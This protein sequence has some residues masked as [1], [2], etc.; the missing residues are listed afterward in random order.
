MKTNQKVNR[1][2]S[3][4]GV[5]SGGSKKGGTR[6]RGKPKNIV[7]LKDDDTLVGGK[8]VLLLSGDAPGEGAASSKRKRARR[9][10]PAL[11]QDAE[12]AK[13]DKLFLL[14]WKRTYENRKR[15]LV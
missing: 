4:K 6:R 10:N 12:L 15:R 1:N 14:A 2:N 11:P 8:T 5:H 3:V 9:P 13:L 7:I